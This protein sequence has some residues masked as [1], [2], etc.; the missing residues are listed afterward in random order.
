MRERKVKWGLGWR[1]HGRWPIRT[2]GRFLTAH[3]QA[4]NHPSTLIAEVTSARSTAGESV[5]GEDMANVTV[6]LH[7]LF[8]HVSGLLRSPH[9]CTKN[10][11]TAPL[12]GRIASAN[13][14]GPATAKEGKRTRDLES[15]NNVINKRIPR[16]PLFMRG[17]VVDAQLICNSANIGSKV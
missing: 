8:V 6:L 14:E 12:L 10:R 17:T 13:A 2:L 7:N 11:S 4:D 3:D 1:R 15:T 16:M 9:N 5:G